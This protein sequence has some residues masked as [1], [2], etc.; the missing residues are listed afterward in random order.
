[1]KQNQDGKINW[2]KWGFLGLLALNLAFSSVLLSRLVT[3]QE[4]T[5]TQATSTK[6]KS[7]LVGN[8]T[9]DTDKLNQAITSYLKPYQSEK[10][11]YQV[12]IA[13]NRIL[14]EGS[15]RL[16]GYDIP[17]YIY[18]EPY[19]LKS[20]AIQLEVTSFSVGTLPL[21]KREVLQY[22]KSSY[23]L[24]DIV[25]VKPKDSSIIINL[26]NL[27][28]NGLFIKAQ[29]IDL[30]NDDLRFEIFKKNSVK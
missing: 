13:S 1:M 14:L 29:K 17:L 25:D 21:P 9:T 22:I 3:K 20:G 5:I 30:F 26:Q 10:M 23:D 8:F 12:Y 16:L 28:E 6:E 18:M 19:K 4:N 7:F 24:P 11:G 15:Y 27:D 2:W